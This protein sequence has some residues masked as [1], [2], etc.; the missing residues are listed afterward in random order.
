MPKSVWWFEKL[1][2]LS[3]LIGAVA[4]WL[5]WDRAVSNLQ[6]AT[7]DLRDAAELRSIITMVL[8]LAVLLLL[9]FLISRV[10]QNWARWVFAV[11]FVVGTP[12][13]ALNLPALI[14]ANPVAGTL[15]LIQFVMQ[16]VALVLIFVPDA[17][18]WFARP[19]DNAPAT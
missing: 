4:A 7:F 3:L 9:I 5:D 15:S 12:P 1:M 6:Q 16:F 17:R 10:R 8:T 14:S 13:S 19:A 18:A 2:W 11:L